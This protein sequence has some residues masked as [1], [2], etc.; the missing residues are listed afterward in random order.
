VFAIQTPVITAVLVMRI[1]QDLFAF[2]LR[3]IEEPYAKMLARVWE[4][5]VK[6][7]EHV[8]K[9]W[10]LASSYAGAEKDTTGKRVKKPLPVNLTHVKTAAPVT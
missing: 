7:E 6:M 2:V 4:I 9:E 8:L 1:I 10:L 3:L 5:R